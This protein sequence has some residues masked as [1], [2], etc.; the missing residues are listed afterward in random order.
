MIV[1]RDNDSFTRYRRLEETETALAAIRQ[2]NDT[3]SAELQEV[4]AQLAASREREAQLRR[5][6]LALSDSVA[7]AARAMA[8]QQ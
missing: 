4:K 8:E 2:S 7:D 5:E 6:Y 1:E 3:N